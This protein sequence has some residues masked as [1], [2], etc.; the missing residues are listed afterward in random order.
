M[1]RAAYAE[2]RASDDLRDTRRRGITRWRRRCRRILLMPP[3]RYDAAR[4]AEIRR[5]C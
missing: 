1:L 2:L 3:R 5:R 4:A